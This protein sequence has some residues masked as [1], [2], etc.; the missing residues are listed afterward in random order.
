[1]GPGSDC[2]AHRSVPTSLEVPPA[3][4]ASRSGNPRWLGAVLR[5]LG[6]GLLAFVAVLGTAILVDDKPLLQRVADAWIVSDPIAPA[7]IVAVFGGGLKDRPAAAA[8]YYRQGLVK[9]VLLSNVG[10]DPADNLGTGLSHVEENR[11]LLLR[12]GVPD[13]SIEIFGSDL[14]ST[15][16]EV[17]ALRIWAERAGV[18]SIIVPTEMFS[19]RRVRWMLARVFGNDVTIRV[20][21]L[22][23][24]SE[25]RRDDWWRHVNGIVSFERELVK[26]L[27]YRIVY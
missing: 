7:D 2:H 18:R 4:Q 9:R 22:E 10:A 5:V 15:H 24:Q 11:E 14:S 20:P 1:M 19:T 17:V 23:E 3:D 21:A 27:L 6:C 25:F 13:S 16:D 12:L 8:A 26:Y